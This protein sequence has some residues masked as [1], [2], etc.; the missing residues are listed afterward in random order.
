MNDSDLAALLAACKATPLDDGPRLAL[1][2]RL[3][4]SGDAARAE[5]VRLQLE[6]ESPAGDEAPDAAVRRVK[7][8]RLL[9]RFAPA[10]VNG[11]FTHSGWFTFEPNSDED[12]EEQA[13]QGHFDR[14]L[15]R[16]GAS[17]QQMDEVFA[18][19]PGHAIPWLERLSLTELADEAALRCLFAR[20][21]T[22]SFTAF[23]LPGKEDASVVALGLLDRDHVRFLSLDG[24]KGHGK[25]MRRLAGCR[26]LRPHQLDVSPDADDLGAWQALMAS[27]VLGE[28]RWL[29]CSI[30]ED[31]LALGLLAG[32]WHLT[33][34]TKLYL[35]ADRLPR[36]ALESLL[37]SSG[38]AGLADFHASGYSGQLVGVLG[39]LAASK[40][41][42]RL[43][44]LDL[45]FNA[46][47][48]WEPAALARSP[49]AETLR[50]LDFGSGRVGGAAVRAL[51]ESALLANLEN[52]DLSAAGA[53]DEA[54][55]A[56]ARSP[57]LKKLKRLSVCRCGLT[58]E[59]LRA[60][61][62]SPHLA[63]L[64]VLDL[65]LNDLPPTAL[66]ALASSPHLGNLRSL[67]LRKLNIDP[68]TFARL[69]RSPVAARLEKLDLQT[70]PLTAAHVRAL[71]EAPGLTALRTL[72]FYAN[73]LPP[74]DLNVLAEAPWLP[75]VASL[76]LYQVGLDDAGVEA[77]TRRLTG[78]ALG[79]LDLGRNGLTDRAAEALL[80]WPGLPHVVDFSVYGN[81]IAPQLEQRLQQAV[82]GT[83]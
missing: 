70:A 65:S 72:T 5:F 30:P 18:R 82:R 61:C 55:V 51:A 46:V 3:E 58:E 69:L 83:A 21:E 20:K 27:P 80:A 54:A 37:G 75:N 53:G 78:G 59:G 41:V 11:H 35:S 2:D 12:E 32:A 57:H 60:L 71:A 52:L 9:K 26:S 34:L 73:G 16:I 81:A 42:R 48:T 44:R 36:D 10:W 15:L 67:E 14:G 24:D 56:I 4:Q 13:S 76:Y 8:L 39:V 31:P 63:G 43:E 49:V 45:G 6:E 19:L 74:G 47:G 25:S 28:V 64:E 66:E 68:A 40:T 17:P 7:M 38:V 62:A 22:E 23:S 77:L 79:K 33:K 1:A 29:S 50:S